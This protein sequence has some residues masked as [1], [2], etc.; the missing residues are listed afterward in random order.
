MIATQS[1]L[2]GKRVLQALPLP[3]EVLGLLECR[4]HV[5]VARPVESHQAGA[6]HGAH[7][8]L[9]GDQLDIFRQF[10]GER[11]SPVQVQHHFPRREL[12]K[13]FL[14]RDKPVAKRLF[15]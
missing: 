1:E 9:H 13:G 5:P 10:V 4:P 8:G 3:A 12:G 2:H 11:Q 6:Q 7:L 14:A 15:V